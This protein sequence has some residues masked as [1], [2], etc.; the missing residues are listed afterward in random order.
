[1][2]LLVAGTPLKWEDALEWLD[3]VR[4]HGIEQFLHTYDR[5]KD[6]R[7]DVLKWGDETEYGIF[8]IDPLKKS[9]QLSLRGAEVLEVLSG[10]ELLVGQD[11]NFNESCHWLPEY[12]AWMV[13]AT[14]GVPYG[15]FASDLRRVEANMRLRRARL[16]SVLHP[17]EIAP[18]VTAFPL[19]GTPAMQN[20][21]GSIAESDYMSDEVI[22]PHPRF[23]TLTAN[24]RKRRGRK[25]DIRVP[26]YDE[27]KPSNGRWS[28][29]HSRPSM[30]ISNEEEKPSSPNSPQTGQPTEPYPGFV[31]MDCMAFGM[32]MCCLQVTFQ[33]KN[34]SESRHLY[35]H[36]GVL[37]PIFLA[38]TAATPIIKG[39]L[40]DTDVRWATISGAV[41]DRTVHESDSTMKDP[42]A[43]P[44]KYAKMAGKGV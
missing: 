29:E 17:D 19:M 14:P 21:K 41:D 16:L 7:E 6:I 8:Q 5:V 2:G 25:V 37:S 32:G 13:E 27:S 43:S 24:I 26:I 39:H 42:P 44:E 31:H 1:M 38:L 11:K 23:G 36:L 28:A 22:N 35:D 10:K 30:D 34:I 20:N 18:T 15:G 12:G 33:A 40:C 4:Q 9:V 3:F